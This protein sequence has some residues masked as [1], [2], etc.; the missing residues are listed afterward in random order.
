MTGASLG[1]E[2][3]DWASVSAWTWPWVAAA[4]GLGF[5]API[6]RRELMRMVEARKARKRM[7][8]GF[9]ADDFGRGKGLRG[10]VPFQT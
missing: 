2:R 6:A 5:G 3:V 10:E 4:L 9:G 8:M 1:A 7:V